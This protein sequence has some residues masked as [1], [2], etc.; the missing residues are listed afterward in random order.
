MKTECLLK[1]TL[2]AEFGVKIAKQ[3]NIVHKTPLCTFAIFL[4]DHRQINCW[5]DYK[6]NIF[7]ISVENQLYH[8][9]VHTVTN[10]NIVPA[11]YKIPT[12]AF[13]TGNFYMVE[14]KKPKL[15]I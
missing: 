15:Y 11:W 6:N 9:V 12:E 7:A 3:F 2:I 8:R 4:T 10:A 5:Y 13:E 14:S 1:Q